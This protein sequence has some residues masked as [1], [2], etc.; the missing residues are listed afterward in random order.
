VDLLNRLAQIVAGP[1]ALRRWAV[2]TLVANVVIVVTGGLVRLTGSGLGCP[3][4]PKCSADSYVTHPAL[5]IH[6]VIEFGNRLLTF[7]LV[8]VAVLTWL[9]ALL[10]REGVR[11]RGGAG[12][13]SPPESALPRGGAGGSSPPESAQPGR[14]FR[15]LTAALA[16]GIPAQA[17]IGGISVLTRLNPFVV[18]LH[19]LVSMVLIALSVRLVRAAWHLTSTPARPA[20][21]ATT[22]LTF[23]LMWLAVWLG[24]VLTGSGPHAGDEHAVRTGFNGVLVAQLHAGVVFATIASTVICLALLRTRAAALLLLVEGVQAA[25]GIIQYLV[26]VPIWLVALHLLGA[27]LAI[28]AATNLL[29]SVRSVKRASRTPGSAHDDPDRQPLTAT[30]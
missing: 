27:A 19:F 22:R 13:S 11:S 5:G 20:A 14:D 3:T 2:A 16:L 25:I 7:G 24:T 8:A 29:L 18:A 15:V 10:H 21:V 1:A 9:S 12:G 28:A 17:V 23:G 26:G 4:W 30:T 6:G